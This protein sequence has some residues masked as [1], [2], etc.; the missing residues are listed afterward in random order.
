MG[1]GFSHRAAVTRVEVGIEILDLS[2]FL[3]QVLL[4]R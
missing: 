4:L 2:M 3:N 1:D